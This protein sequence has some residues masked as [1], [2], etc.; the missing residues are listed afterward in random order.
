VR[1]EDAPR[2]A[3]WLFGHPL[4]VSGDEPEQHIAIPSRVPVTITYLDPQQQ[5]QLAS[6]R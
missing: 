3:R 6:L 4:S 1:L 5:M 2:L